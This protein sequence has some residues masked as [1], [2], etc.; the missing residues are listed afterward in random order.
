M[1]LIYP[2]SSYANGGCP[3]I[4]SLTKDSYIHIDPSCGDD[5]WGGAIQFTNKLDKKGRAIPETIKRL[6]LEK[7]CVFNESELICHSKGQTPLAGATFKLKNA[8]TYMHYCDDTGPPT[9][10]PLWRYTCISGCG[11]AV[12]KYLDQDDLCD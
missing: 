10:L 11:K 5:G 1:L 6:P 7:E 9:E 2:F 8:G 4:E 12:P 3:G